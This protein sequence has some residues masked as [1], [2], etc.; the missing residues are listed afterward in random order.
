MFRRS[1][2]EVRVRSVDS[3]EVVDYFYQQQLEELTQ[4]RRMVADQA[5]SRKR[6]DLQLQ[7]AE[8][9]RQKREA[10]AADK[11]LGP[12]LQ[13]MVLDSLASDDRKISVLQKQCE[14]ARELEVQGTRKSINRQ[15]MVEAFAAYKETFKAEYI[16]RSAEALSSLSPIEEALKPTASDNTYANAAEIGAI[17][18]LLPIS[19]SADIEVDP[20][21]ESD[22]RMSDNSR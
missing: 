11:T 17:T 16:S 10:Q 15:Q 21:E 20:P 7:A 6:M 2:R 18:D 8:Q 9:Q 4:I 1:A 3:R 22:K 19:I 13:Q 12:E 5:T 14:A